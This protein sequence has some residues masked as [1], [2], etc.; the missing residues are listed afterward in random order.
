MDKQ[1][2]AENVGILDEFQTQLIEA[3]QRLPNK[4]FFFTLLAA[5]LLLFQFLGNP[6][7]GYIHSSSL[8]AWMYEAYNSPNP[9]AEGDRH[10]NLIPFLVLGLFWWKR[11]TLLTLT[12]RI[13]MPALVVLVFGMMLHIVGYVLQQPRVCIMGLFT[14]IYGLM[15]LS[16]GRD[17]LRNSFFPFFLFVFCIPL[18]D[19]AQFLTVRLQLLVCW[20]VEAITHG[21]GIDVVRAGTRLFDPHGTYQYEV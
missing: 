5:W 4:A 11:K 18:G 12:H 2:T 17:W 15:G 1:A 20:L 6:I 19:S 8:F 21:I 14:G 10:G 9:A 7:L 13:W 16:W 3:W